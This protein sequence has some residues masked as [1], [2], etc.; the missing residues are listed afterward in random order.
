MNLDELKETWDSDTVEE[1]PEV[2]LSEQNK[3]N[4]PLALIRKNMRMEFWT[5]LISIILVTLVC[6]FDIEDKRL[7]TYVMSL[8]VMGIFIIGYYSFKFRQFYK[9]IEKPNYS[10]FQSLLELNYKLKYYTDLYVSY[11]IA[12]A[13]IVFCEILL[14][15]QFGNSF[16]R[17]PIWSFVLTLSISLG[18]TYLLG[19]WWFNNYYGKHI[20]KVADLLEEINHPYEDFQTQIVK[21]D[22][23]KYWFNT[24][25]DF[26]TQKLGLFGK[27]LNWLIWIFGV[28]FLLILISFTI[29]FFV[30]YFGE[31]MKH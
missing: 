13:P 15:Y 30:G 6:L 18:F 29:G 16:P 21:V 27:V 14:Y 10:T 17:F 31:M 24:T 8:I 12:A 9:E 7:L 25:N 19:K 26:L 2:S 22:R 4:H 3:I 20:A 28:L 11:Y 5:S 23:K 1:I